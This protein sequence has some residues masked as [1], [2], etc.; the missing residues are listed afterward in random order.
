MIFEGF[1]LKVIQQI[2]VIFFELITLNKA[3]TKVKSA[4]GKVLF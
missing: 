4:N 3:F 2:T 1:F